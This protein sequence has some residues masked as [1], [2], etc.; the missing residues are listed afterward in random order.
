MRGGDETHVG[1]DCLVATDALE[2]LFLEEAQHL[3]LH[4]H[5][6]VAD[7]IEKE[8]AAADILMPSGLSW[9]RTGERTLFMAEQFAFERVS[10]RRAIQRHERAGRAAGGGV[11]GAG[12]L[13]LTGAALAGDQDRERPARRLGRWIYKPCAWR[14]TNR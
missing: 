2:R 11:N 5:R 6:H 8:R 3:R 9:P 14:D 13:L 7:L 10:G 1:S 4:G 12:D